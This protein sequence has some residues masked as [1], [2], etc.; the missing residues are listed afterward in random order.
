LID[1]SQQL[2]AANQ[3]IAS[4]LADQ[5]RYFIEDVHKTIEDIDQ[6]PP[7]PELPTGGRGILRESCKAR[8]L[9]QPADTHLAHVE[10]SSSARSPSPHHAASENIWGM[11]AE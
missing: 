8:P 3:S 7:P 1:K 6:L 11:R 5:R 9:R 10:Q 4:N 2:N